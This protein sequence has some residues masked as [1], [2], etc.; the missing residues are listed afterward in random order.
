[1]FHVLMFFVYLYLVYMMY[2]WYFLLSSVVLLFV[3]VI[4]DNYNID[5]MSVVS[6]IIYDTVA[7]IN[8]IFDDDAWYGTMQQ[9][10]DNCTGLVV[11][12]FILVL[13][14]NWQ[15][16]PFLMYRRVVICIIQLG[17]KLYVSW[18]CCYIIIYNCR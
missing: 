3:I 12:I 8:S 10:T 1:M 7:N 9:F 18:W 17:Y 4:R 5:D 11:H 14:G 6:R 2:W 15:S 16:L 13:I